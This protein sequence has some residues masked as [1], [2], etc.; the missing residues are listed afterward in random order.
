M[1]TNNPV[2]RKTLARKAQADATA[3]KTTKT[4]HYYKADIGDRT[5]FRATEGREYQFFDAKECSWSNKP[6]SGANWYPVVEISRQAYLALADLKPHKLSA[7]AYSYAFNDAIAAA[8]AKPEKPAKAPKA[9]PLLRALHDA[10][11]GTAK[12]RAKGNRAGSPAAK[13]AGKNA[14]E[15]RARKAADKA[16]KPVSAKAQR[17]ADAA[18]GKLPTAPDFSAITH[19]PYRKRLEALVALVEAGDIHGLE[20]V[21]MLPPRSSSPKALL[22]YRDAALIAL[23]ARAAQPAA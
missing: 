14:A 4:V 20:N 3:P 23:K 17:A 1:Q 13:A 16:P 7:P 19:K 10:L 11:N 9:K 8:P 5:Y 12:P 6:Q 2:S 18:A 22:R 15:T 21:P